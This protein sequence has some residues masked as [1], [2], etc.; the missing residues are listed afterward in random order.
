MSLQ[1]TLTLVILAATLIALVSQRLRADVVALGTTLALILTG[2]LSPSEAFS[3]FSQ[4]VI[5]I[6]PCL[7][8]LGAAIADTG[9][10]T[11]VSTRLLRFSNRG[12]RVLVL[13]VMLT[14]ALMSSVLSSLLVVAALMPAAIRISK[15]TREAPA[16]LLLPLAYGATMGNLLTIIAAVSTVLVGDLLVVRG[17]EPLG[18][19]NVTPFG[20]ASLTVALLWFL[21]AGQRLLRREQPDSRTRP[22][23]DEVEQAYRLD[24]MLYRLRVRSRSSLIAQRL[25]ASPLSS[26]CQLNVVAVQAEG[27]ILQ[28]AQPDWILEQ[29]DLLIVEG[30]AGNIHQAASLYELEP[31]GTMPLDEFN[32]LEQETLRL[33]ELMVPFRSR[34][35]G[36]TLADIDFRERYGLNV[37]AVHRRGKAIREDLK[38]LSLSTG[39]TLLV[40]GPVTH[41]RRIGKDLNLVLVT[42]LGPEPGDLVTSK[43][44]LTLGILAVMLILTV[45]GLLSLATASLAA[46]VA[47]V[48]TRCINVDRAY[49]SINGSIIVTIGGMLPLSM[50]LQK[51]GVAELA[52]DQLGSL[53]PTIGSIGVVL[54]LYLLASLLSQITSN[55][56]SATLVVPI[57]ISLAA[58]LGLPVHMV[59][60][61]VAVAVTTSYVTSFTN[62][63]MLLVRQAGQYTRKDYFVNGLPVFL[64]QTTA[65]MVLLTVIYVM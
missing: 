1:A 22:S 28:P 11:V 45:S 5:V 46:V 51:T 29:D 50:A 43:A 17:I 54:L 52:A 64:L 9:V 2:V 13:A 41:V 26:A 7:Y 36:M 6:I 21:F 53:A 39:D 3:A 8:V 62:A 49:R 38:H 27:G 56:V 34:W 47:L 30:S 65:V 58:A 42:Y 60:I 37:L 59:A 32:L 33:A 24:K 57:G 14:A 23:L 4:P 12:P 25:D 16:Q 18:F 40:Q 10:A 55:S 44:R 31:K 48:L 35:V 20:L 15:K 61:A 19:L 63:D